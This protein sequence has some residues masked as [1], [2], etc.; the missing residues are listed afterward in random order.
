MLRDQPADGPKNQLKVESKA[1]AGI[2]FLYLY[3]RDTNQRPLILN[4]VV[5]WRC[6]I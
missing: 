5:S 2:A 1:F 6:G 3:N 4:P